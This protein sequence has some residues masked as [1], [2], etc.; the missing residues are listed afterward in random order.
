MRSTQVGA[1]L[2]FATTIHAILIPPSVSVS[3]ADRDIVKAL[4]FEASTEIDGR[5]MTVPC[6]GC[7]VIAT[8]VQGSA[9]SL[10]TESMLQLN[11]SIAHNSVDQLLLNGHQIYPINAHS[12][13][14]MEALTAPQLINSPSNTWVEASEPKLGYSLSIRHPATSE[15]DQLDLVSIKF[16]IVEV[17]DKFIDGIASVELKLLETPSGKLMIGSAELTPP[18]SAAAKPSDGEKE[19]ATTLCKWRAMLAEKLGKL[20]GCHS[21]PR[22]ASAKY[23]GHGRPH[24]VHRPRPHHRHRNGFSRFLRSLVL[25]VFIPA[26]VGIVAGIAASLVGMV[27]GR[28]IVFVWRTIRSRGSKAAYCKVD[29]E[30]VTID[31]DDES[32]SFL[33]HQGPPPV[34]EESLVVVTEKQDS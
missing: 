14:F 34:Y 2:A 22:P 13:S 19:C 29:Q 27:T 15:Q 31:E 18:K 20:K 1:I 12:G 28:L 32:K 17:A 25:L 23:S 30:D 33:D 10:Q 26:M 24:T 16:G 6:P 11:F 5:L 9:H 3:S 7:P 21:K 8:D 4:P